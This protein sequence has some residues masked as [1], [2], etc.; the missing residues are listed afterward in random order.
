M[1]SSQ[2]TL[3]YPL[4]FINWINTTGET[5]ALYEYVADGHQSKRYIRCDTCDTYFVLPKTGVSKAFDKHKADPSAIAKCN[6]KA[7][8]REHQKAM[9]RE[10]ERVNDAIGHARESAASARTHGE[11]TF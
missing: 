3:S 2:Y 1:P 4:R 8:K 11:S 7:V 10:N 9:E 5:V 6:E